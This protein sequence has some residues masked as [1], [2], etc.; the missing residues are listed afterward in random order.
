MARDKQQPK[1]LKKK[2]IIK[3][4]TYEAI[5]GQFDLRFTHFD[6]YY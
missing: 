1:H 4:N 2:H 6:D 3:M 5:L